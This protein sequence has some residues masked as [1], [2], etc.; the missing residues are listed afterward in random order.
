[1]LRFTWAMSLCTIAGCNAPLSAGG[2]GGDA[3]ADTGAS[4][5]ATTAVSPIGH[6]LATATSHDLSNP[7]NFSSG[8]VVWNKPLP[9]SSF[10]SAA[11]FTPASAQGS[12]TAGYADAL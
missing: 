11:G 4:D 7:S 10:P 12:G 3:G 1:M 2:S 5:L 8:T 9:T 6:D